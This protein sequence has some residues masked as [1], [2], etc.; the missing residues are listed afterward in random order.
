MYQWRN[1]LS[2]EG[3]MKLLKYIQEIKDIRVVPDK[4]IEGMENEELIGEHIS[5]K[6]R[7]IATATS[8]PVFSLGNLNENSLMDLDKSRMNYKQSQN[9]AV[10]YAIP[11]NE[12]IIHY[13]NDMGVHDTFQ[14]VSYSADEDNPEKMKFGFTYNWYFDKTFPNMVH[15]DRHFLGFSKHG[16]LYRSDRTINENNSF[17]DKYNPVTTMTATENFKYNLIF[18]FLFIMNNEKMKNEITTIQP[19]PKEM[20]IASKRKKL[21]PITYKTLDLNIWKKDSIKTGYKF[22]NRQKPSEHLRRGHIRRYKTGVT[23]NIKPQTINKGAER[24]TIKDYNI[25]LD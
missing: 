4:Q 3:N 24:K 15:M 11:Y 21:P 23:I 22:P 25:K 7:M 19:T 13:Q 17:E 9:E 16:H 5:Y 10:T 14:I 20:K 1:I 8:Y 12:F 6:D 18:D 2:K